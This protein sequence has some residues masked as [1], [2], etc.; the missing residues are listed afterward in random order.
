MIGHGR[1]DCA[2]L[3][4]NGPRIHPA[5]AEGLVYKG[6]DPGRPQWKS[7]PM[8]HLDFTTTPKEYSMDASAAKTA[9]QIYLQD[10]ESEVP[11][12]VRLLQS[13]PASNLS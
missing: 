8:V 5:H 11:T 9:A 3:L 10:F 12:T 2:I 6:I 7:R 1:V 4:L 13:I